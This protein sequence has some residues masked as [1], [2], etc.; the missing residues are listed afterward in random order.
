MVP[1]GVKLISY[2]YL[3]NALLLFL[4][5]VLFLNRILILGQEASAWVAMS[6]RIALFVVPVYL[7]FRLRRLKKEAWVIAI[8]FHIFFILNNSLG[9]LEVNDIV[10]SLVKIS[11]VNSY[12]IASSYDEVILV[13]NVLVNFLMLGYLLNRKSYFLLGE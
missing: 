2:I 5:Q 8:G 1:L 7:Y 4:S 10:N 3:V 12:T 11:G 9:F 13:F 6:V